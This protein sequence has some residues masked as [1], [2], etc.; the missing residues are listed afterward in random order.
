MNSSKYAYYE[1]KFT[2]A[3]VKYITLTDLS[4]FDSISCSGT[5]VYATNYQKANEHF[6]KN[7]I[8][9]T[10]YQYVEACFVA[11]DDLFKMIDSNYVIADKYISPNECN[12][13]I[14]I[15]NG[16]AATCL[17]EGLTNGKHCKKCNTII[18]KQE[19]IPTLEHEQV[20]DQGYSATYRFPYCL[21]QG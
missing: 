13:S 16:Y 17:K 4:S 15:D 2:F 18:E 14:V 19:I 1:A 3:N 8:G 6:D 12:H 10:C 11:L 21:R 20:V 9:R 5:I 7:T